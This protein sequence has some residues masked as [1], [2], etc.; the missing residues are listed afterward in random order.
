MHFLSRESPQGPRA[1]AARRVTEP[2]VFVGALLVIPSLILNV[3]ASSEA[4][5]TT[6]FALNIVSWSLFALEIAIM[7]IVVQNRRLWLTD[8]WLDVA[9]TALTVPWLIAVLEGLRLLRLARLLST[10]RLL[11]LVRAG[12]VIH[13]VASPA[14]LLWS[15]FFALIS[16]LIGGATF[17][18]AESGGANEVGFG[19]AFWWA[20]TTATTV[21]Y[22]DLYPTTTAGRVIAVA[23]MMVGIGL[24][25]M[26]TAAIAG[27]AAESSRQRTEAI[28]A[29]EGT[30]LHSEIAAM[31][32]EVKAL[33]DSIADLA[34]E[35][36]R[37]R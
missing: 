35:M 10:L 11:R 25:A 18:W 5:R 31:R 9:V 2:M 7:M 21:G 17:H 36:R 22:G 34:D 23:L 20:I 4:W 16:I 14:G 28:E 27:W 1:A 3:T 30:D 15:F 19:D 24:V 37:G 29:E 13:R 12:E 33:Q 26:L 8:H 6:G 32:D